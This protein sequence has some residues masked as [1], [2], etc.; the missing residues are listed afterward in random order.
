MALLGAFSPGKVWINLLQKLSFSA[1]Y[2]Y[3]DELRVREA[4]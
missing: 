4:E 3:S 2:G 1:I